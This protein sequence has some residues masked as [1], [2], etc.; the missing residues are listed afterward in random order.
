MRFGASVKWIDVAYCIACEVSFSSCCTI[1]FNL[2]MYQSWDNMGEACVI[3][4]EGGI[5][6]TVTVELW[7]VGFGLAW[8]LF[9]VG[10]KPIH[11]VLKAH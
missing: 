9:C 6:C 8:V 11:E 2:L 10:L 1:G 4:I 3:H 5:S 7:H